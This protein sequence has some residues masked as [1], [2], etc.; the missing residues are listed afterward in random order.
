MNYFRIINHLKNM[1]SIKR[2]FIL[3]FCSFLLISTLVGQSISGAK[4]ENIMAAYIFNFTKFLEWSQNYDDS[5][6]VSV[7]GDDKI[8]EPLIHLAKK[9]R[10]NGKV[11]VVDKL[12]DIS[13]LSKSNILFIPQFHDDDI[14]TIIKKAAAKKILTIGS[15]EN[16][17]K[18]GIC[19][20]FLQDKDKIKFEINIKSLRD[21]GIIPNTRLLKIA[22]KIYD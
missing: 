18:R 4:A 8:I 15:G 20:N 19:I 21:A 13:K 3:F 12:D 10:V 22:E 11:I 7:L 9:E 6:Y 5:F 14:K 2:V 1:R 16:L 17:A